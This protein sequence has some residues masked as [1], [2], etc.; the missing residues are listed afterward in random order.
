MEECLGL[1]TPAPLLNANPWRGQLFSLLFPKS[2]PCA[3]SFQKRGRFVAN[4]TS[5]ARASTASSPAVQVV[6]APVPVPLQPYF[7]LIPLLKL[8]VYVLRPLTVRCPLARQEGRIEGR[9]CCVLYI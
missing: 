9:T 3:L 1:D 4:A 8:S 5:T 7:F 6:P 2:D